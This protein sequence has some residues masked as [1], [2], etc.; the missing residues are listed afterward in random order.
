MVQRPAPASLSTAHFFEGSGRQALYHSQKCA[1]V[2]G[3]PDLEPPQTH[4]Q[5]VD[6]PTHHNKGIQP[7]G[8]LN[9]AATQFVPSGT[10]RPGAPDHSL[11]LQDDLWEHFMDSYPHEPAAEPAPCVCH[12]VPLGSCPQVIADFISLVTKVASVPGQPS[13]MDGSRIPLATPSFPVDAWWDILGNYFDTESLTEGFMFGWDLSLSAD[14]NPADAY[15]NLPSAFLAAHDVDT[16]VRTELAHGALVGPIDPAACPFRFYHN[17]IGTV[18]KA[19]S[20]TRRTIIDCSQK[21]HGINSYIPASFH[22]GTDWNLT[23][24]TTDT[25][26]AQIQATRRRYPGQRV[27]LFKVDFSRYYRWFS[28][29]PGQVRYLAIKW[30]GQ[31]Y[32]D[33]YFSFGNRGAALA[34]QR[35]SWAVCHGFRTQVP[36]HPGT[37]NTGS[38]CRCPNHCDCGENA[39]VAYIDDCIAAVPEAFSTY[40]YEAFI[41]LATKLGMHMSRTP[42]HLSPP[43]RQ[44]VAL[45]I[46][47]DLDTNTVSLPADKLV[48][49]LSLL[50]DWMGRETAT[51]RELASLAGKLLYASRVVRPGRIFLNRV[52]AS[53][54]R[55]SATAAPIILDSSFHADIAWWHKSLV[56]SNGISFLEFSQ[57]CRISLDASSSGWYEGKPGLAGFNHQTGQFFACAAPDDM[58]EWH[59]CDLE[60][61]CHL[62]AARAWG[63]TW[64]GCQVLGLT[65]N[66][67]YY[68][69]IRNGR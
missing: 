38:N 18:P 50:A 58:L 46:L 6:L 43:S 16:Y 32:L 60:L 45:G 25:I 20:S 57:D 65:D 14:P 12:S 37:F 42:G 27:V 29:D 2:P 56:S 33:R 48:A 51:V 35:T 13:N 21:G 36:P 4:P 49:I 31:S 52:L 59:I 1:N 67:A 68:W 47:F 9:P 34:A 26:V 53:K 23:L 63:N 28:L 5:L 39:A 54:R 19:N 24:P 30:R 22:R 17:P 40:Q 10:P 8:H 69:R 41:A 11:D 64:K 3:C 44:C 15:R 7:K 55:A 62:I 66:S 61:V